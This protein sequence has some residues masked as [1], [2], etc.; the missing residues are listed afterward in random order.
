MTK[1]PHKSAN[2]WI[3]A[4]VII[5]LAAFVGLRIWNSRRNALPDGIATGNG[6]IEAELVDIV[7]KEPL[8]V[9]DIFVDEGDLVKNGQMLVQLNTET[10][11]AELAE[12]K[13]NVTVVQEKLS[14]EKAAI[15]S[16][17]SD[18]EL[19]RIETRRSQKLV[20]D[21]AGSQQEYDVNRKKLESAIANL[22]EE[23]AKLQAAEEDVKVAQA[24]VETIQTRINDATL[25]SPVV[26]RVLYR[27]AE[28]GEV[29]GPGGKALTLVDLSDVYMEIFLPSNQAAA[30]KLGSEGRIVLDYLP[31][32]ALPASVSFVSPEAQFTPKQVETQSEREMLMF[33]VKLQIPKD[34]VFQYIEQ[35]KT[36]VRGVG[37]VKIKESAQWP[38]K[39]QNLLEVRQCNCNQSHL[40]TSI[41]KNT[42][43]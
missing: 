33:R 31:D 28:P 41:N 20:K 43:K 27:L 18:V 39:L 35:I 40:D 8:R 3:I 24:N 11:N 5:V 21:R 13:A 37:Y 42:S 19:A 15:Q 2:K 1:T 36:G 4:A 22:A 6:R 16:R 7:A 32:K 25:V 17:N 14:I 29:L 30:L 23:E 10:L 34:L 26:G 38:E 9:K 12:A